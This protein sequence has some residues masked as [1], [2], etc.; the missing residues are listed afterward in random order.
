MNKTMTVQMRAHKFVTSN[1]RATLVFALALLLGACGFHLRGSANIP[2]IY[3]HLQ[4]QSSQNTP[5]D[6]WLRAELI[7]LRVQLDEP[8][9]IILHVLAVRP[10]RQELTGSLT[11]IQVGVEVDFRMENAQ[12]EPLTATRTISSHRSFQYNQ[13]TVGIQSQQEEL[14]QS[15]LYQSA[16]QQIVRQVATGRLPILAKSAS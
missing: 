9:S 8:T 6:K 4:V 7:G 2:E 16:A 14:L 13:N 10:T 3:K 15:D 1:I 11:E 12:G 5:L